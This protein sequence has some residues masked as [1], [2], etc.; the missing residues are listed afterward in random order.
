MAKTSIIITSTDTTGKTLQKNITDVNPEATNAQL[1]TFAQGLNA[2]TTN[3][4]NGTSRVNK[5]NCDA[6]AS[7]AVKT[8]PTLSLSKTSVSIS[9]DT[10]FRTS[11]QYRRMQDYLVATYNGDGEFIFPTSSMPDGIV[12][13]NFEKITGGFRFIFAWDTDTGSFAAPVTIPI[14]FTEGANYKAI[15][16]NFVINP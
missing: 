11:A 2:L 1:V 10:D 6:E 4:Y 8:T 15:S 13:T 9:S 3:T 7:A 5:I 12:L 14:S 16:A